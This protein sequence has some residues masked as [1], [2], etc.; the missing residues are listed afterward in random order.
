MRARKDSRT[1][2]AVR[3][4]RGSPTGL[5]AHDEV[6][7]VGMLLVLVRVGPAEDRH[8]RVDVGGARDLAL[9]QQP[10]VAMLRRRHQVWGAAVGRRHAKGVDAPARGPCRPRLRRRRPRTVGCMGKGRGGGR[11]G[12]AA[13]GEEKNRRQQRHGV[14]T[15]RCGRVPAGYAALA[16][17]HDLP[18][19]G[20]EPPTGVTCPS[21]KGLPVEQPSRELAYR[22]R[23]LAGPAAVSAAALGVAVLQPRRV[24]PRDRGRAARRG[25]PQRSP[26]ERH[27][28]DIGAPA[29]TGRRPPL[30]RQASQATGKGHY[31]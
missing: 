12:C 28:G 20:V 13:L 19:F 16:R 24:R 1:G 3:Q 2:G 29:P 25:R 15:G 10:E 31:Y 11:E 17:T 26:Q 4:R 9:E 27:G 7:L 14:R 22:E 30:T 21:V 6:P 5:L 23:S 18:A 8:A